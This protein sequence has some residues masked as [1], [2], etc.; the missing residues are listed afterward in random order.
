MPKSAGVSRRESTTTEPTC[1]VTRTSWVAIAANAPFA[2]LREL[3]VSE[4][5][6][7]SSTNSG[8]L[9]SNTRSTFRRHL[10]FN[11]A[12]HLPGRRP[13]RASQNENSDLNT[14]RPTGPASIKRD[15]KSVV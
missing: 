14:Q 15:R 7:F 2:T 1:V 10:D 4:K 12:L 11:R 8:F 9:D 13:V 3:S 6:K 5:L